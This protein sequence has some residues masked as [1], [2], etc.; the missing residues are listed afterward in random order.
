MGKKETMK[1]E[2]ENQSD[3]SGFIDELAEK[4]VK[5]V[6]EFRDRLLPVLDKTNDQKVRV[7][8]LFPEFKK[9]SKEHEF[10]K[11]LSVANIIQPVGCGSWEANSIARMTEEGRKLARNHSI[12]VT[13][14]V[15]V[16]YAH[17]DEE[18]KNLLMRHL[19]VLSKSAHLETWNDDKIGIGQDFKAEIVDA[20]KLSDATVL[21]ISADFFNS[22]FIHKEEIP[23]ILENK[24]N[25]VFPIL[26]RPCAW[27]TV[28]WLSEIKVYLAEGDKALSEYAN[29]RNLS[30]HLPPPVEICLSD[31]TRQVA[32][33]MAQVNGISFKLQ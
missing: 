21:I 33:R 19:G 25:D 4:G 18:W 6:D 9:K 17:E 28:K 12:P 8:K 24:A 30:E 10:L 31:F 16:S 20:L 3:V 15:F 11:S 26:V 29:G 7:R 14:L 27:D 13:P 2:P 5:Y 32:K 22:R 23:R 1:Q